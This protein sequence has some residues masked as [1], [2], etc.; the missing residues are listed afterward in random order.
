MNSGATH[1]LRKFKPGSPAIIA[2]F[3]QFATLGFITLLLFVLWQTAHVKWTLNQALLSHAVLT[4]LMTRWFRL[5][6]WWC[7]IQPLFPFAMV[8]ALWWS[9]PPYV[10][11]SLFLFLLV[12]YWSTYR[13]QVPYFPSTP[14]AWRAVDQLLPQNR[15]ISFMDIGSGMG[16]L[17]IYLADQRPDCRFTGV[18]IA[19]LP[20]LCSYLRKG[21]QS[22]NA[23]FLRSNYEQTD[24][25]EFDVIFA[26]LSPAAMSGLWRKAKNEMRAGSILISYEF[27]VDGVEE[28]LSIYPE[29]Y[30]R[31]QRKL[32]VWYL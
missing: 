31:N 18:E 4:L 10:Y 27:P 14:D 3:I 15:S 1:F 25:S 16:G 2:L 8:L 26:Y 5:A 9:L 6:W 30:T 20:W 23:R 17:V 11:L 12:F 28:D 22:G 19:P 32:F 21:G 13:T 29:N 7:L 24:F